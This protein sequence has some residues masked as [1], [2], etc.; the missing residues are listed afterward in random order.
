MVVPLNFQGVGADEVP[1]PPP[2]TMPLPANAARPRRPEAGFT[3]IEM[4]V[5]LLIVV[6]LIALAVSSMR[7]AKRTGLFRASQAAAHSYAE[8]VESYMA[9]NGQTPPVLGGPDWPAEPWTVRIGGP[10]DPMLQN[11]RYLSSAAPEAVSDGRVDLI[12]AT[13]A[14]STPIPEAQATITYARTP[15]NYTFT[16]RTL[17][18]SGAPVLSCVITNSTTI[19]SGSQRC[20]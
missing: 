8:A 7:G 18:E 20:A 6:V 2:L 13:G 4:M 5:V 14:G 1:M 15:S 10:R 3:L 11:K 17:G 16:V 9:D 12:S 19:P